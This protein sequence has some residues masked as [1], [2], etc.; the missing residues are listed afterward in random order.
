MQMP[1]NK[2]D[3][4][5]SKKSLAILKSQS[6]IVFGAGSCF[7]GD[8]LGVSIWSEC[9]FGGVEEKY[10]FLEVFKKGFFYT[11]SSINMGV[12]FYTCSSIN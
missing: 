5:D 12:L 10:L 3:F 4:F 1:V 2:V 6:C 9:F 11:R 8:V 7:L